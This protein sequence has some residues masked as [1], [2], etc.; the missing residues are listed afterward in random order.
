MKVVIKTIRHRLTKKQIAII[1]SLAFTENW[2][3]GK[4]GQLES[5]EI[6]DDNE[7]EMV[8]ED[9]DNNNIKWEVIER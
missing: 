7:R 5:I 2:A 6:F 8:T 4:H 9:L 3:E 1:E